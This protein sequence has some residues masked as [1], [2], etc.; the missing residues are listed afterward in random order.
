MSC[1]LSI[2]NTG[3]A[4]A[5]ALAVA[6]VL[7]A[8]GC[9]QKPKGQADGG[10]RPP[11]ISLVRIQQDQ[12]AVD[13]QLTLE[14]KSSDPDGDLVFYRVE[15]AVNGK[16]VQTGQSQQFSTRGLSPGDLV[17]ARVQAS[18]GSSL[19]GWASSGTAVLW[20]KLAGIDGLSLEP[21]PLTAGLTSVSAIPRLSAAGKPDQMSFVFRWTVDGRASRD[22]GGTMSTEPLR[23][24]QTVA[25]EAI[26]VMGDTRGRPFRMTAKVVG[27]APVISG[28]ESLERD[29]LW[30]NYRILA[31]DPGSEPLTYS[32]VSAPPGSRI[33]QAQGTFAIPRGESGGEVVLRVS[34]RSGSWAERRLETAP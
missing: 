10:N 33:D 8:A 19:S 9:G 21:S 6:A 14:V 29:S 17:A 22:S 30:D 12:P 28:V 23:K 4:T 5:A 25:V 31:S 2:N 11:E 3:K 32:L 15:W 16:A 1:S 27:P 26:P 18:D 13:G 20:P 24:G 7:S 34:N